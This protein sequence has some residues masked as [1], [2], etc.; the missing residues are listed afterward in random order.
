MIPA[1]LALLKS[2]A[3]KPAFWVGI[4]IVGL[5]GLLALSNYRKNTWEDRAIEAQ[6]D[7]N[8]WE[9]QAGFAWSKFDSLRAIG[10]YK[11]DTLW[12]TRVKIET[13]EGKVCTTRVDCPELSGVISIDTTKWIGAENPFGVRV[14][15]KFYWPEA[16]SAKNWLV[17]DVLGWQNP[18]LQPQGRPTSFGLTL[19]LGA[20][21]SSSG[22]IG[23]CASI[24][25]KRVS[26]II[27]YGMAEKLWTGSLSYNVLKF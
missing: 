11:V 3:K 19:G 8:R 13:K 17:M 24:G 14:A 5:L 21:V 18:A 4:V 12:I 23:P 16:L 9:T 7:A 1:L 22:A 20:F 25:V 26:A 2:A 6:A 27:G 10:S 15:G